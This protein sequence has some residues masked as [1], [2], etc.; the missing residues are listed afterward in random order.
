[1]YKYITGDALEELKKL[2]DNSVDSI[3]TDPPYFLGF[4]GMK[5]DNALP[6]VAVWVE[7]LRVLKPGGHMLCACGTRTQHRMVCNI[8]DAMSIKESQLL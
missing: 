4:M 5:W 8:E 6:K 2:P 3:V 1:M 7:A